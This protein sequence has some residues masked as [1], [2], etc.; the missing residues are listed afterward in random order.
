MTL[1]QQV[2]SQI[3]YKFYTHSTVILV[4]ISLNVLLASQYFL[5]RQ[6]FSSELRVKIEKKNP[7]SHG[8]ECGENPF[9]LRKEN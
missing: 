8:I 1:E 9:A 7:F 5:N 2:I 4:I 6:N 3:Q